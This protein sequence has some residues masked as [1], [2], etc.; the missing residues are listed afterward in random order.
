M[1]LPLFAHGNYAIYH[2]LPETHAPCM[3]CRLWVKLVLFMHMTVYLKEGNELCEYDM[4]LLYDC[5]L[6]WRDVRAYN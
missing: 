5:D 1:A 2:W 6:I 3:H 4:L